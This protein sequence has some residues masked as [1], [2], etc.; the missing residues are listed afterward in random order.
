MDG[1]EP[2]TK[3]STEQKVRVALLFVFALLTVALAFFQMRNAVVSPFVLRA[4]ENGQAKSLKDFQVELQNVDTDQDG[5]SDYDELNFHSTS[6][7]LPDT[8]SDGKTDKQEI[9]AGTDPLCAE[10][11]ICANGDASGVTSSSTI[12]NPVTTPLGALSDALYAEEKS[13]A[14][15]PEAQQ[16]IDELLKDPEK[17]RELLKQS[18][19]IPEDTLNQLDDQ[20]LIKMLKDT[21]VS[22]PQAMQP[23]PMVSSTQ[24]STSTTG[25]F[26]GQ[27]NKKP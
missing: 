18:G 25:N 17:I 26:S 2:N 6:P 20:T 14:S 27:S 24:T 11:D 13:Q 9:D 7:Y 15:A 4:E 5:I 10:G 21:V 3:L 19:Q 8:D 12:I 1:L 16:A 23:A 22:N